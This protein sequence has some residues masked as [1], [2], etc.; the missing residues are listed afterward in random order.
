MYFPRARQCSRPDQTCDQPQHVSNSALEGRG[1]IAFG[2]K[3]IVE[4]ALGH[5]ALVPLLRTRAPT[6]GHALATA[7]RPGRW[8]LGVW[9]R[10]RKRCGGGVPSRELHAAGRT[11][12]VHGTGGRR[13]DDRP[14]GS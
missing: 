9:L 3:R 11:G 12:G 4:R 7:V 8:P 6:G 5:D 1:P 2:D 14:S 10:R 13:P